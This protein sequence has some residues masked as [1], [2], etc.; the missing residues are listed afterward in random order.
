MTLA[1]NKGETPREVAIRFANTGCIAIL[2]P[3]TLESNWKGEEE[4][5]MDQPSSISKERAKE[6]VEKLTNMLQ[7]AKTRFRE[8]GGELSEDGEIEVLKKEQER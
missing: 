1:N 7:L 4:A 2:A 3:K 6:R 5:E 8:L